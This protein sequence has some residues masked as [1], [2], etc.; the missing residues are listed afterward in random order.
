MR[1]RHITHSDAA[2]YK[3]QREKTDV[4]SLATPE[5]FQVGNDILEEG[6]Q[7]RNEATGG[8]TDTY[9]LTFKKDFFLPLDNTGTSLWMAPYTCMLAFSSLLRR[10]SANTQNHAESVVLCVCGKAGYEARHFHGRQICENK[11]HKI[12]G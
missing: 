8:R 1:A 5:Q 11:H 10:L 9:S 6:H 2:K 12:Y 4:E 3:G 7:V